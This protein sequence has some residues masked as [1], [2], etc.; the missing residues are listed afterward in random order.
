[1]YQKIHVDRR[2]IILTD[3]KVEQM[4]NNSTCIDLNRINTIKDTFIEANVNIKI[5][6]YEPLNEETL[7]KYIINTAE[8]IRLT[9]TQDQIDDIKKMFDRR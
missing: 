6:P 1:M 4:D 9:L 8:N 3:F 7:E 5:I 2:V